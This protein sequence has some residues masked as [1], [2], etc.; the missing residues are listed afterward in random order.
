VYTAAYEG[1][2]FPGS[3][4]MDERMDNTKVMMGAT[5][6]TL[7]EWGT[8]GLVK[9]H[10]GTT[11]LRRALL[12]GKNNCAARLGLDI[13]VKK[14]TDLAARAGLGEMAQDPSTFLGRGE[15]NLHDLCLAYTVFPNGGVKP[16]N[17]WF[18]SRIETPD[19]TR[20][21]ERSGPEKT[22]RVTDRVSAWMTHSC[23]EESMLLDMGTAS[24]AKKYGLKDIPVAGKTGTHINST[25]LW[26]AGYS[27]E[28]TCAVWV[29]VDLKQPVYPDAF[30]RHTA[31]P[32]WVDIMNMSAAKKV[33]E[34]V[35]QPPNVQ[36]VE[37]CAVSGQLAT[38]SCLELGP[39]P[40]TGRQKFIKCSYMEYIRPESKLEMRCTFHT[41]EDPSAGAAAPVNPLV[42]SHGS[43]NSA[44]SAADAKPL[45]VTAP[46]VLGTDPYQSITGPRHEGNGS[47]GTVPAFPAADANTPPL[48]PV[49]PVPGRNT[50]PLLT[51]SPGKATVD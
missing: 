51:P 35:E 8:E 5:T 1:T 41:G 14:V 42:I 47:S 43:G 24:I 3:R 27:S 15:V 20:I 30:S 2:H 31:L 12:Q 17:T 11:S 21:Y 44:E 13:G 26:F 33:P 29:G 16:V 19:G 49:A 38:D 10:D 25:D 46:L 7:G 36:M 9:A 23:L 39:D 18:V 28:V 6:G 4:I 32:I 40:V 50:G 45:V 22:V 48:I 37:L 34:P